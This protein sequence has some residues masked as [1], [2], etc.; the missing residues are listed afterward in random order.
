M[1][2]R[3]FVSVAVHATLA[4]ALCASLQPPS[5]AAATRP[6]PVSSLD[7]VTKAVAF[8]VAQGSFWDPQTAAQVA[9]AW[10]GTAFIID[11]SGLAVT[12]NHVIAGAA[13][14]EVYL[15]GE[16]EPRNAKVLGRSEC[17]DLAV[18]D[19]DGEGFRYL[20][21]FTG[22][23][24]AGL[25][26]YAVGF[27]LSNP[28][29]DIE[30]GIISKARASGDTRWSFVK[31]VIE[32]S[33]ATNPGNSGGPIVTANGKVVAVHFAGFDK[34]RQ[35]FAI[36]RDEALPVI[37]Q[38]MRERDVDSIGINPLADIFEVNG[39]KFGGIWVQ[40]VQSGSPADDAELKPGD[41]LIEMEGQPLAQNGT[42]REFCSI[43]RSRR[44]TDKMTIKVLRPSTG[45]LLEG[46]INGRP[47]KVVGKVSAGTGSAGTQGSAASATLTIVN[48]SSNTISSINIA[49]PEATEWGDNVLS[50]A[51]SPGKSTTLEGIPAGVYDIRALDEEGNFLAAIFSVQIE[52]EQSWTIYPRWAGWPKNAKELFKDDFT[53]NKNKWPVG[54]TNA[55]DVTLSDGAMNILIK[56]TEWTGWQTYSRQLSGQFIAE[57]LCRA[58]GQDAECALG[59]ALDDNNF[60]WFRANP[61]KQEY[62]LRLAERGQWSTDLIAP[63]VSVYIAPMGWNRYTLG[64]IGKSI[65]LYVNGTLIDL[66]ETNKIP[67]G[68][69]IFGGSSGTKANVQLQF[70]DFIVFSVQ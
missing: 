63:N 5:Q 53:N 36:A 62:S 49:S 12:N 46:Q 61:S 28:E 23:L 66:V 10:T 31:Q 48:E 54:S 41:L 44:P 8:V 33:A 35:Y 16:K 43:I 32:H 13:I 7:D 65:V 6:T 22:T 64:R 27:P 11:P 26:I 70:D 60:L 17:S 38:L 67:R 30:D 29:V 69:V 18:I 50:R 24:K 52:G 42:M 55:F 57:V 51:I 3:Q 9:D 1:I 34:A 14:L 15:D 21:W 37:R 40:A 19:I 20:E 25:P 58:E 59:F 4:A 68:R 45:E 2:S 39:Q 47:L 56:E